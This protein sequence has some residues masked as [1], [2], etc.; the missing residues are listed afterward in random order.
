M[1]SSGTIDKLFKV[2]TDGITILGNGTRNDPLR[3]ALSGETPLSFTG[4]VD[5]VNRVFIMN[6]APSPT[7]SA[8]IWDGPAYTTQGVDYDISGTTL[9]YRV[10]HAPSSL[11]GLSGFA[12]IG[13]TGSSVITIASIASMRLLASAIS[14]ALYYVS[15]AGYQGFFYYDSTDT[16]SSDNTGTVV[17]SGTYRFKRVFTG[18]VCATWFGVV[19]DAVFGASNVVTGTDNTTAMQL[20]VDSLVNFSGGTLLLPKG[21]YLQNGTVYI[22][23][24]LTNQVPIT[25]KGDT[26]NNRVGQGN[27]YGGTVIARNVTGDFFRVN[28]TS[29]GVAF[30]NPGFQY[31]SFAAENL[32]F[33]GKK[34]NTGD[35]TVLGIKAFNMFRTRSIMKN[36]TCQLIDYGV[37]QA[38]TDADLNQ[39]YCDQ[40]TYNNIYFES[41][42]LGGLYLYNADACVLNNINFEHV[43]PQSTFNKGIV[44]DHGDGASI[45]GVVS[46]TNTTGVTVPPATSDS[47]IIYLDTTSNVS[48]NGIHAEN[49][50]HTLCVFSVNSATTTT[51]KNVQMRFDGNTMFKL[52][53]VKGVSIEGW[54]MQASPLSGFYDIQYVGSGN[55]NVTYSNVNFK[56]GSPSFAERAMVVNTTGGV[57]GFYSNP[58]DLVPIVATDADLAA[59]GGAIY[60][61][62][63][64]TANRVITLPSAIHAPG[65]EIV[66]WNLNTSGF[67]W[68]FL[69]SAG[70]DMKIPSG[71]T[72]TAFP[73][74][75]VVVAKG[76]GT[77]NWL[78]TN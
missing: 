53:N 24:L 45:R 31:F 55:E 70:A 29:G 72:I 65:Q 9:T 46:W 18:D 26:S 43:L 76:Y 2:F 54:S 7:T 69:A 23:P 73:N 12:G 50:L 8:K 60:R 61:L 11:D 57:R 56:T 49:V 3:S 58:S 32:F 14:G 41:P 21:K 71:A 37:Y 52:T 20:A 59:V 39:N 63:V 28:L 22:N 67:T 13:V 1:G 27:G 64:I 75:T 5:G 38:P 66:F 42:T 51:V 10:G 47:A 36:I 19:A 33:V 17:V 6:I 4:A 78:K 25:I 44:I 35:S 30:V 62:P 74:S 34:V 16:T 48:I 77:T 68:T 15:A 40:S